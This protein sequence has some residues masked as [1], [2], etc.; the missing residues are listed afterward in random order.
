MS[1]TEKYDQNLKE[2]K[3]Y[4][5]NKK[6]HKGPFDNEVI[7]KYQP[8]SEEESEPE[9][10]FDKA[11]NASNDH[12]Y[13]YMQAQNEISKK[14]SKQIIHESLNSMN[15]YAAFSEASMAKD[16]DELVDLSKIYGK[17]PKPVFRQT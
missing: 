2:L 8:P 4:L 1:Q 6:F 12:S 16:C 9:Y 17:K 14:L 15:S 10:S 3:T 7:P 13:S 11:W 5:K